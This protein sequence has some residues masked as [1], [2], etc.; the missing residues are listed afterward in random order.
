M[1]NLR[2]LIYGTQE[3]VGTQEEVEEAELEHLRFTMASIRFVNI[4]KSLFCLFNV[5][6]HRAYG[7]F[8]GSKPHISHP[9]PQTAKSILQRRAYVPTDYMDGPEV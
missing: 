6:Y 2:D 5:N 8:Y 9:K 1:F 4:V 7:P 3:D